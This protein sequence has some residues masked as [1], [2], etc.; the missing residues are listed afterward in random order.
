MACQ[1]GSADGGGDGHASACA[2]P[3]AAGIDTVEAGVLLSRLERGRGLGMLWEVSYQEVYQEPR[4]HHHE[5]RPVGDPG[6]VLGL[7][8]EGVH[9]R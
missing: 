2:I 3:S 1:P 7:W 8:C 6:A 4:E 9:S 5:W